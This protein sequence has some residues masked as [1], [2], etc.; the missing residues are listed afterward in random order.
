VK[1]CSSPRTL[2]LLRAGRR[3]PQREENPPPL[4]AC[5]F[6]SDLG[7]SHILALASAG[8]R[9]LPDGS[10][11]RYPVLTRMSGATAGS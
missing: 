6:D 7:H 2:A 4:K 10:G 11:R 5:R 8:L 3:K 1:A 9:W